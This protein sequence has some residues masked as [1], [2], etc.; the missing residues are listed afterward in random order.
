MASLKE[1]RARANKLGL[2]V[3]RVPKTDYW[4]K[5]GDRYVLQGR[6]VTRRKKD[7]S[8]EDYEKRRHVFH[9]EGRQAY[10]KT[11]ADLSKDI[12]TLERLKRKSEMMVKLN[13]HRPKYGYKTVPRKPR[14][15]R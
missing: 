13:S 6:K 10:A 12:T 15:K 3:I 5:K 2:T 14:K 7:E 4:Y 1:C 9:Y 11:V 8:Y